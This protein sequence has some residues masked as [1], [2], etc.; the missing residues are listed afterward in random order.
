MDLEVRRHIAT[1]IREGGSSL[2]LSEVGVDHEY[3]LS[4]IPKIGHVTS[5]NLRGN[6]LSAL[7]ESLADCT[8]LTTLNLGDNQ[9]TRLP[10]TIGRLTQLTTLHLYDNRLA[11]LPASLSGCTRLSILHLGGNG[12]DAL[13]EALRDNTALTTLYLYDNRLVELTDWIGQLSRLTTLG[14][15]KNQ[16]ARLPDSIGDLDSLTTL[17]L[18]DNHLTALP[19]TIGRLTALTSVY[20]NGNRLT[21]LPD[22]VGN[23]R[24]L[25]NLDLSG[26]RLTVLPPSLGDLPAGVMNLAANPLAPELEAAYRESS[27]ELTRFLRLLKS[28]GRFS[29]EAKLVLVGEGGVGKSSLLSALRDEEW[30][31]GRTTTHGVEVKP[32]RIDVDGTGILLNGWDFGGQPVYR[33]THQLFFS[34]PAVYLVVW[35]PREGPEQGAVDYWIR[36][37]KHR[38]G[39]DARIL[40]VATHGGP[41]RRSAYIDEATILDEYGEMIVGFHHV[42]SRSQFGIAELLAKVGATAAVLPHAGRWYPAT[43][44][45]LQAALRGR[46]EPYLNYG[47]YEAIAEQHG[48]TGTAAQSLAKISNTLGQW[49]YYADD[50]SLSDMVILKADWLATAVSFVLDDPGTI[51][52]NGLLPH[53]MLPQL[54]NS[55]G[56]SPEN[57][58]APRVQQTFLQLMER[59]DI[60]YR[61]TDAD[62][63]E[64]LSLV[65]QLVRT[66]RPDLSA[67]TSYGEELPE[68]VQVCE[69]VET[70]TGAPALPEGLMYQLI[71]RFH[72]FSLGRS[73]FRAGVHWRSGM[74]LDNSYNGRALITIE[75]N[76]VTVRVRAAYPQFLLHQVT[77]DIRQHLQGFWKGLEGR[78]KVPCGG[79]CPVGRPGTGLFDIDKLA[80]S[81]EQQR[82][83]FPCMECGEWQNID[84]LLLGITVQ[85]DNEHDRLV[86]A[87]RDAVEP[88]FAHVLEELETGTRTLLG[89]VDNLETTTRSAISRAEERLRDL[90]LT[91]DD[92]SRDGPRLFTVA[93][94]GSTVFR[95]GWLKQRI[96]LTVWCEH[97]RLPVPLLSGDETAGV[98]DLDLP[99]RWLVAAAPWIRAVSVVIRCLLPVSLA[100]AELDLGNDRWQAISGQLTVAEKALG[101]LTDLGDQVSDTEA[102]LLDENDLALTAPDGGSAPTHNAFL[103]LLH[104]YLQE[105][106]PTFAR[107]GLVRVRSRN[108][109]LWVHPRF[110]EWYHQGAPD[111][112]TDPRSP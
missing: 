16:L 28:E 100:E 90:V 75:R 81:R 34:A 1:L 9:L 71:V 14:V 33:P 37:I 50:P 20:L 73:D 99:R 30:V 106:D 88:Q 12:L 60:S 83:E 42:D 24:S 10:S 94:V 18:D 65:A 17:Y 70:A 89:S 93:V 63:G 41:Q 2:D 72:R 55:P 56:R 87:V 101:A 95:P 78:I 74:V 54:W 51:R 3:L 26:N 11:A 40:V 31:E 64:P 76:R 110:V 58:Y 98:Y 53:R 62:H 45:R 39:T 49:I 35:K 36:L 7:P 97:S 77:D 57:R 102:G 109:Y 82:D 27:T 69:I 68:G 46:N 108:R 105:E 80:K 32:L 29:Y 48:L 91:F 104:A 22:S 86:R 85:S 23:L 38:A 67:W 79:R 21:S 44:Q 8:R 59:F 43:W 103:R 61:V 6:Q 15:S 112:P 5:L 66:D 84:A 96:R 111:I 52:A 13:P 4:I 47:E 92:E 107:L 19:A 25:T